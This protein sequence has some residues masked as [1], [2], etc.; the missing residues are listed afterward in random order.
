MHLKASSSSNLAASASLFL[1]DSGSKMCAALCN[2]S[3][4]LK[5]SQRLNAH[6]GHG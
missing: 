3:S 2:R 1:S 4:T 6:L 5:L